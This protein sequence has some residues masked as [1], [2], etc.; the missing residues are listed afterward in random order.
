MAPTDLH[1]GR[2]VRV[3]AILA[4]LCCA[5]AGPVAGAAPSPDEA[6][7][8]AALRRAHP[9]TRFSEVLRSPVPGLYEVW[10][11]GNVAFVAARDPR[12]FIFG[13][14][15]DTR[16]MTDLTGPRLQAAAARQGAVA[17]N[18][19]A[20]A[21]VAFDALPL[22][23]AIKT[24]RGGG[25]R[26]LAVFSDPACSFCRRLE[27]ELEGLDDV[28]IHTFLV[29][30]QGM[31]LP[32]AIWCAPDRDAAWRA[33]MLRGSPPAIDAAARCDHP[34]ERNLELARRLGVNGTPTLFW[35]DGSRTEGYVPRET[36]ESQLT[37]TTVE[38]KP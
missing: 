13:R 12:Y 6:K 23:D 38:A 24:V 35:S 7:L 27:P 14:L 20:P 18:A 33:T 10:M 21:G 8:I 19:P 17:D 9:G 28:T 37:R 16:T 15:F 11:N 26:H 31:A 36:I 25:R 3:A 4:A 34:V 30:F 5:M 2:R 32:A 22:A 1:C 29:P